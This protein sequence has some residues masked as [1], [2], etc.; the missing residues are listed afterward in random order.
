MTSAPATT[1]VLADFVVTNGTA[2]VTPTAIASVGAVVTLTVPVIAGTTVEQS[3]VYSVAYKGATAVA[4]PAFTIAIAANPTVPVV[5]APAT[6]NNPDSTPITWT[7]TNA[8][9]YQIQISGVNTFASTVYDQT[10]TTASYTWAPPTVTVDTPYYVRIKATGAAGTTASDWSATST[11]T[12]KPDA[13]RPTIVSVTPTDATHLTVVFSEKIKK[14]NLEQIETTGATTRGLFNVQ[15]LSAIG[16]DLISTTVSP[17]LAADQKTAYITLGTAMVSSPNG[18]VFQIVN[19]GDAGANVGNPAATDSTMDLAGNAV[20]TGSEFIFSGIGTADTTAPTVV[21]SSFDPS[22]NK[23]SVAFNEPISTVVD[24]SKLAVTNGT[25]T[26]ALTTGENASVVGSKLTITLTTATA[27]SVKAL[28]GSLTLNVTAA[29]V[30]DTSN[31]TVAAATV[32]VENVPAVLSATYNQLTNKATITFNKTVDVSTINLTKFTFVDT[33]GTNL[34]LTSGTYPAASSLDTTTNGT[35][36]QVSVENTGGSN[37]VEASTVTARTLSVAAGAGYDLTGTE[38]A[39]STGT[40]VT[41]TA[42]ATV[43]VV[44]TATYNASTKYIQFT[45]PEKM[46]FDSVI[47]ANI[48]IYD[49][50]SSTAGTQIATLTGETVIEASNQ[51]TV[52]FNL[53]AGTNDT[54]IEGV[55]D[56]TK[57]GVVLSANAFSDEAGN[58]TAAVAATAPI[59][60]SY[61]DSTPPSLNGVTPTQLSTSLI[62]IVYNEKVNVAAATTAAN[63]TVY[64]DDNP[65]VTLPVTTVTMGSD[66]T[67]A[68]ITLGTPGT[69]AFNYKV[70]VMNVPDIYGNMIVNSSTTNIT[71]NWT[72]TGAADTTAPFAQSV[73][74]TDVNT[75]AV[76]DAGD[77]LKVAFSEP[78]NV[79]GTL[80]SADFATTNWTTANTYGTSASLVKGANAN[81]ILVTLGTTPGLAVADFA[82]DGTPAKIDS[83]TSTKIRDLAGNAAAANGT[84]ITIASPDAIAPY[85]TAAVYSDDNANG[86]IDVGDKLTLTFSEALDPTA[87]SVAAPTAAQAGNDGGASWLDY[88]DASDLMGTGTTGEYASSNTQ[89]IFTLNA[90]ELDGAGTTLAYLTKNTSKVDV[91]PANFALKDKWQNTVVVNPTATPVKITSADTAGPTVTSAVYTDNNTVGLSAGDFISLTLSEPVTLGTVVPADFFLSGGGSFDATGGFTVFAAGASPNILKITVGTPG[92]TAF[93]PGVTTIA[94]A[95]GGTTNVYDASGNKG[96]PG[97]AVLV[98]ANAVTDVTAPTLV[99]VQEGQETVVSGIT[100]GKKLNY[101]KFTYSEPVILDHDGATGGFI[102]V[103]T[104]NGTTKVPSIANYGAFTSTTALSD[105]GVFG[106]AA[107]TDPDAANNDA[108]IMVQ[109]ADGRSITI[110]VNGKT[111]YSNPTGLTTAPTGTFTATNNKIFDVAGNA[112]S[113][114]ATA[115]TTNIS[116]GMDLTKPTFVYTSITTAANPVITFTASEALAP[117]AGVGAA[118]AGAAAVLTANP[119]EGGTAWTVSMAGGT[120]FALGSNLVNATTVNVTLGV[121][122]T[123]ASGSTITGAALGTGAAGALTDLAGNTATAALTGTATAP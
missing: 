106:T 36:I 24:C 6:L 118:V 32:A 73:T 110:Y 89:I 28:T 58:Y 108:Q 8:T 40:A 69:L 85:M 116:T 37:N 104:A 114:T 55:V 82:A 120:T 41:Y 5:T 13:V 96:L 111:G 75:N 31:N 44:T 33:G 88:T 23:L 29:A 76:V 54:T 71:N 103:L 59:S 47:P 105:F 12:V 10:S 27:T 17:T 83:A 39:V 25:S 98:S 113:A 16:A 62:S 87:L 94:F 1:P 65:S 93:T 43:P 48:K 42:D 90:P 34:T 70:K 99:S 30:K 52:S 66:Q 19:D 68:F 9:G 102:N 107:S 14:A 100:T 92:T 51:T 79:T 123:T 2:A 45:F 95:A 122:G 57:I 26:V 77:T 18:Y 63:Y 3:I 78:I 7:S 117:G 101:I 56:K 72:V 21:A 64:K 61:A 53:T 115:T 20:T 38:I 49:Y 35:T 121:A 60:L 74:Y 11:I 15:K 81:E 86:K 119:T 84:P 67:T 97:N 50:T 91:R 80:T 46:K 4:A 112:L 109:S 22:N